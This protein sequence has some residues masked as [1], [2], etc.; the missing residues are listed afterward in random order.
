VRLGPDG[1]PWRERK[2]R[3]SE[4]IKRDKMIEDVLENRRMSAFPGHSL[5]ATS[6]QGRVNVLQWR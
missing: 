3:G 4:D 2:R 6:E 5:V 1:K